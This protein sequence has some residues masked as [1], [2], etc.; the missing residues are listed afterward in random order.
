MLS[1]R[2]RPPLWL[3]PLLL[4]GCGGNPLAQSWQLDRLRVLAVKGEP[5]EPRPGETVTF[6]SLLYLPEGQHLSLLTW[7][8]CLPEDSDSFGCTTD[9]TITEELA[10]LDPSTLSEEELAALQEELAE[11]GLIGAEP[12]LPP[13][14]T[15]PI[16]ALDGLSEEERNEGVSAL[17]SL[18]AIPEGALSASDLELAFK[19]LPVSEALTPNHNPEVTGFRVDGEELAPDAVLRLGW[20]EAPTIEVL[21]AEDAIETYLY[22]SEEGEQEERVEEPYVSWFAE[23]GEFD[24]PYGLHP[25]LDAVWTAPSA[26]LSSLRWPAPRESS[27]QLRLSA[28]VRDRRGGMGWA[29]LVVELSDSP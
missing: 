10:G 29:S 3:L 25:Y 19:R 26:R 8:A 13:S 7:F 14:W 24:Q 17:V 23:A 27:R 16:D 11:A 2:P 18:T 22:L 20:G 15:V 5:A 1:P 9:P 28:V 6:D 12:W 21:L 4:L